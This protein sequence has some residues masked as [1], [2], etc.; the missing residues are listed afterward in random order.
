MSISSFSVVRYQRLRCVTILGL[1]VTL[2]DQVRRDRAEAA[3]GSPVSRLLVNVDDP[4]VV[5]C[6]RSGWYRWTSAP[7]AYTALL[8]V[9]GNEVC[10]IA[11]RG[12]G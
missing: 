8:S 9:L 10:W 12:P 11:V 5:G 4:T 6:R 1:V 3:G 2:N 7:Y